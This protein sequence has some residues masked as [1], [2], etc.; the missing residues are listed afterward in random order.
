MTG[1][2]T[3]ISA[4]DGNSQWLDGGSMFGN[5]PRPLWEKW[6]EVDSLGRIHLACRALLIE[7]GG[8]KILCETGIGC[9]FDPKLA[10][11][12]GV[13]E[14][15]HRLL[16][17]LE[18]R[19][20]DPDA[21]DAVIL[22]HLH[23]D[24]A[25]GLLPSFAEIAAGRDDLL[26]PN[27]RY[28]VGK[29]AFE[30]AKAPHSRD[31]ASFIP[32]LT[33]KLEKSGRLAIVEGPQL[34]DLYPDRLSFRFSDGHTP[35]HMHTVFR[36]DQQTVIFCGDLIPGLPWLHLPVTMGYDRFAELVIDEKR[37]LYDIATKNNWM[38]FF[39]HDVKQA[40]AT[41]TTSTDG[42]YVAGQ[43]WADLDRQPI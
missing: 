5:A 8:K 23:F 21:I 4:I 9:F 29:A 16:A 6:T 32:G 43:V 22:S 30:R 14:R 13:S 33:E 10:A 1:Q 17:N 26:F 20:I 34:P 38:L 19:G 11:R 24:H 7:H 41:V 25:G 37:A 40:A 3:L 31:R 27:A 15:D 28:V 35:G 39:T 18:R 2:T 36:G 42:K 12:Y